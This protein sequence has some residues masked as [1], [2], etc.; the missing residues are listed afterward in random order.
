MLAADLRL[1]GRP[2]LPG[3]EEAAA[4]GSGR[5]C[6]FSGGGLSTLKMHGRPAGTPVRGLVHEKE[7]SRREEL[8]KLPFNGDSEGGNCS[9]TTSCWKAFALSFER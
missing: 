6:V 7:A 8:D 1:P 5:L 2:A 9:I 3:H 4:L